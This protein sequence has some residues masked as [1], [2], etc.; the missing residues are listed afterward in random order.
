MKKGLVLLFLGLGM[1]C[2]QTASACCRVRWN[3][4]RD[5]RNIARNPGRVV[6]DV[7]NAVNDAAKDTAA[8][9]AKAGKDTE[10]AVAKAG[11]DT[12]AAVAKAAKDT[13]RTLEKT[14]KDTGKEL[15]NTGAA[16]Y[17]FAIRQIEAEGKKLSDFQ[18]RLMKGKI[19]DA[20]AHL[21]IDQFKSD[22]L[23]ASLAA[24]ESMI[25][26]TAG[27][28]VATVYGGPG[29]AAAYAAWYTYSTTKDIEL[30]LKAGVISG[31]ASYASAGVGTMASST[32]SE[33]AAKA[34]VS[35]AVGGLAVAASGGN[36]QDV[37]QGFLLSGG[38]VIVQAGFKAVAHN[39]LDPTPSVGEAYCMNTVGA[40]CSPP[41][42]SYIR[43]AQGNIQFDSEGHPLVD[44]RRTDPLRPHVGKWTTEGQVKLTSE[45]GKPLTAV[46]RIPLM[47]TMAMF[48]DQWAVSWQMSE[49]V[50]ISTI[51]IAIVI[52]AYGTDAPT[53]D[54]LLRQI[55][56]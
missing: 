20:V 40:A 52:T 17:H 10:V 54:K 37:L 51:P 38:A 30:A 12:E 55:T 4:G 47:N 46:S 35:G 14:I 5:I 3:P 25:L 31:L 23:N 28:I 7:T 27:Q 24:Q 26:R 29:G 34:I 41:D 21:G 49:P 32:A 36:E 13:G 9:V 43:D 6:K 19:L 53:A 18:H 42:S 39:D 45:M 8:A 16:I 11:K 22:E 56:N 33:I 50:L 1:F 2:D 15:G 48:H 44:V